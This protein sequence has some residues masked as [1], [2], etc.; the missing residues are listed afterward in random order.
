MK[1]RHR[2]ALSFATATIASLFLSRLVTIESFRRVQEYELDEGLLARAREEGNHA[3]VVGRKAVEQEYDVEETDPLEQLVTYGALYR[4]DGS[5]VADTPSFERA[6]SLKEIGVSTSHARGKP[7]PF[8]FR[9]RDQLLRGVLVEV[10]MTPE[11]LYLLF[12]ASRRDM[13][14]DAREL[15]AVGW[16]VAAA[17]VPLTLALGWWLGGRITSGIE[18]LVGAARKVRADELESPLAEVTSRDDEVLE[19]RNAL[20]DMV[21]RLGELIHLERKF[22]SHAAHELRSP[23]AALRGEL[24]LALRRPR[25]VAEYETTL[26]DVLDDTNRLVGLSE[27][28]LVVARLGSGEAASG[29][30]VRVRSLL[31]DAVE[32]S[33]GRGSVTVSVGAE[34]EEAHVIG[35]RGPLVRAVRNLLDNAVTHGGGPVRVEVLATDANV[36]VAVEDDGPGVSEEDA[37]R[38]FDHF[39]RSADARKHSGAGLGLGIAREIARQ[40]DGDV[41]LANRQGPTRFELTLPARTPRT[42]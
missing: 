8:D 20:H 9:Y 24:E 26:K 33:L 19:L 40:H 23:L 18:A 4:A 28:L 38:I 32:S 15:L 17:W 21:N 41:R 42:L 14:E 2:I 36:V 11:P 31:D 1:L 30:S 29:E 34:A 25:T 12:A 39:H 6:P 22:A 13:D 35:G 37:P 16:W 5:V 10:M 27:D 7:R 3:A